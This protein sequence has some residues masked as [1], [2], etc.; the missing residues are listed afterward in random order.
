MK[1]EKCSVKGCRG[2]PDIRLCGRW[3]CWKHFD[4]EIGYDEGRSEG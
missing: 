3:F 1:L 4:E 2:G